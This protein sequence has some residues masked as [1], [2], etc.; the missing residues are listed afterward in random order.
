MECEKVQGREAQSIF[1]EKWLKH[2]ISDEWFKEAEKT[3]ANKRKK[4]CIFWPLSLTHLTSS[5]LSFLFIKE[6]VFFLIYLFILHLQVVFFNPPLYILTW[7]QAHIIHTIKTSNYPPLFYFI[8][9]S[10]HLVNNL[11][12]SIAILCEDRR[13]YVHSRIDQYSEMCLETQNI[14]GRW[15]S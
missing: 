14:S 11:L 10:F 9:Y 15:L 5:A 6:R 3:S 7:I 1:E 8:N 12:H 2:F 13:N 4:I